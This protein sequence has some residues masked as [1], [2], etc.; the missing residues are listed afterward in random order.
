MD[1][2]LGE[3]SLRDRGVFRPDAVAE[4]R[5]LD[6]QGRVDAAYPLF[7]IALVELWCRTF[8]DRADT[9]RPLSW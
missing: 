5:R 8:L 3:R 7:A 6:E 4:L 2:L 9:S 1:E